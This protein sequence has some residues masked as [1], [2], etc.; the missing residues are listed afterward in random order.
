MGGI[1]RGRYWRFDA[2]DCVTEYQAPDVR[3]WAREGC[4]QPGNRFGR[5]RTEDSEQTGSILGGG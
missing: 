1:G 4:L 5:Q 3:R 2:K